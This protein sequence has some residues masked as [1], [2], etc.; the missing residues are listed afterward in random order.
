MITIYVDMDGVLCDFKKA[1]K[2][3]FADSKDDFDKSLFNIFVELDGFRNLD[4]MSNT[5][6]LVKYLNWLKETYGLNENDSNKEYN[7]NIEVLTSGGRANNLESVSLQKLAW[8]REHD[9]DWTLNVVEHKGLK[10]RFA[11]PNSILID[12][13]HQN[14]YD[15]NE[16]H[17]RGI[18]YNNTNLE[19][20]MQN[21][22]EAVWNH[23]KS[24]SSYHLI[25]I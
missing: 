5:S 10:K 4:E 7:I 22:G 9:I 1:Y 8:L 20:A 15:F 16:M 6:K 19:D 11:S 14:I 12:D 3:M 25:K 23:M 17:G 24:Q 2:Q 21:I 13:T 18:Y